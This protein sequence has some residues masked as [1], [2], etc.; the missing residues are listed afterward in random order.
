MRKKSGKYSRHTHKSFNE[1]I[2][3][4]RLHTT[5]KYMYHGVNSNTKTYYV[6]NIIKQCVKRFGFPFQ[7][8]SDSRKNR[9]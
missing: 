4:D 5:H 9:A 3:F 2:E 6:L 1:C 7:L 8:F